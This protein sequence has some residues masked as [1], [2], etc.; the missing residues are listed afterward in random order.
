MFITRVDNLKLQLK[1][2][3]SLFYKILQKLVHFSCRCSVTPDQVY[4]SKLQ[5]KSVA[6]LVYKS[7]AAEAM[8][9]F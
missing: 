1:S 9:K 5:L 6:S 7:Y 2:I 4:G 3:A 8:R